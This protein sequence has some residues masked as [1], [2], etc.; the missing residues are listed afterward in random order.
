MVA[1][2]GACRH[3]QHADRRGGHLYSHPAGQCGR[4]PA[5]CGRQRLQP[6]SLGA[7]HHGPGQRGPAGERR[8]HQRRGDPTGE[9]GSGTTTAN[10]T[11]PTGTLVNQGTIQI[12]AGTGGQRKLNANLDNRGKLQI[13]AAALLNNVGGVYT[14]PGQIR[15]LAG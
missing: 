1:G 10:L 3:R 5:Q 6:H 13:N 11:L 15:V 9:H 12:N 4:G 14:N 7:G 2:R 8:G